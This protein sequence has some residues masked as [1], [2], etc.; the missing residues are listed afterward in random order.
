[1]QRTEEYEQTFSKILASHRNQLSNKF[2]FSLHHKMICQVKNGLFAMPPK[3][4][5]K[6]TKEESTSASS[7]SQEASTACSNTQMNTVKKVLHILNCYEEFLASGLQFSR[8]TVN[9]IRASNRQLLAFVLASKKD[10][11]NLPRES[12][13]LA[14]ILLNAEKIELNKV[15]LLDFI[16]EQLKISRIKRLAQLRKSKA[17]AVLSAHVKQPAAAPTWA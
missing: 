15:K 8:E 9:G 5:A 6:E 16:G 7:Q 17:Y 12:I 14:I 1:M 4:D 3:L 11:S 10:F 2:A 13:A